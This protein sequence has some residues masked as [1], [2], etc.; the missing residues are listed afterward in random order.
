MKTNAV[1]V[2]LFIV[3]TLWIVAPAQVDAA[4]AAHGDASAATTQDH[5]D[6]KHALAYPHPALS[7]PR[8]LWPGLMM[9]IVAGMFLSAAM[10]GIIVAANMPDEPPPTD[11]HDDHGHVDHA[12]H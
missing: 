6:A 3:L 4:A 9:L 5:G 12:H 2:A 8:T 10:V 7:K 11:S 1:T